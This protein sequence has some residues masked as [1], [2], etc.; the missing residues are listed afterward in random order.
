MIASDL[1]GTREAAK[2]LGVHRTRVHQFA[3]EGR[4]PSVMIGGRLLYCRGDVEAFA[5][6]P[7]PDGR[8]RRIT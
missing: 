2:I 1:I 8:P 4:L 5:R 3:T 6:V 7:R